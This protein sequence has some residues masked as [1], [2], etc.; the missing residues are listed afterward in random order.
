MTPDTPPRQTFRFLEGGPESFDD[1]LAQS[2]VEIAAGFEDVAAVVVEITDA[3]GTVAS[4]SFGR[5]PHGAAA[6]ATETR[7]L[8]AERRL[9]LSIH[10]RSRRLWSRRARVTSR[11]V[12]RALQTTATAALT[13]DTTQ[14]ALTETRLSIAEVEHRVKNSLASIAALLRVQARGS[15]A[16]N[17]T[18]MAAAERVQSISDVHAAL[19]AAPAQASIDVDTFLTDLLRTLSRQFGDR[20]AVESDLEPATIA[21]A[22][23]YAVG[24]AVAELVS[25]SAKHAFGDD[26]V[27]TVSVVGRVDDDRYRIQVSDD[28]VGVPKDFEM[29]ASGGLGL[30]VI[31]SMARRLGGALDM[32]Q[33]ANGA[34]FA[35]TAAV[36]V[37]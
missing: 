24:L 32:P 22:D 14:N 23:G 35:F 19:N 11:T 6:A 21:G 33:S 15:V 2:L 1:L 17:A 36:I 9:T 37:E 27:G 12:E 26:G 29:R 4:A 20:I 28:G 5:A 18:L 30:R 7:N 25:N 13:L 3:R 31:E 16:A 10:T 8:A 34:A